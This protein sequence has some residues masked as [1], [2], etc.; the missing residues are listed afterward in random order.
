MFCVFDYLN[1]F[2]LLQVQ[3]LREEEGLLRRH[4]LQL[5]EELYKLKHTLAAAPVNKYT[6]P[7][8]SPPIPMLYVAIAIC[9]SLIGI[10][11]GKFVL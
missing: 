1:V 8:Q 5:R 2:F 6:P 7:I 11:M 9:C 4:N 10:I 3:H